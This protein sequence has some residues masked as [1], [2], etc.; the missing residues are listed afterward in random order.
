MRAGTVPLTTDRNGQVFIP[1]SAVVLDDLYTV[2]APDHVGD[3]SRLK[4]G[5]VAILWP[6]VDGTTAS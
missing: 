6:Q 5:T 2:T 4:L 1:T 3:V